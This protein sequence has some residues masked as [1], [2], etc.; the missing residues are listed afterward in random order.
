MNRGGRRKYRFGFI[1]ST[2]IGNQTHYLNLRKFVLKDP[3]V[4]SWWVG[5]NHG[6]TPRAERVLGF[7]PRPLALRAWILHQL[8][9]ALRLLGGS[10]AVMIHQFEAEIICA[11]RSY[12]TRRP[13]IVSS[14]DE[15]PADA[16]EDYPIYPG[17]LHKS[18]RRRAFRLSLDRWRARRSDLLIPFT[19]WATALFHRNADVEEGKVVSIHVGVDLDIW[20]PPE[21]VERSPGQP[22]KILFV[23]TDFERKGGD[24]LLRVFGERF[25]DV[26]EL[27]MVTGQLPDHGQRNV[28]VHTGLTPNDPRLVKLYG[29]CDMLVLPTTADLAPWALIEA[30]A[31]SRPC[32]ATDIGAVSE[33]IDDGVTGFVIPV[34]DAAALEEKIR[35]L[36]DHPGLAR[37]MGRRGRQKVEREYDAAR[38]VPRIMA[39]MKALVDRQRSAEHRVRTS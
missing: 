28:H 17:H 38:N 6:A 7:L 23:G 8:L 21:P 27:H 3:E 39:A 36:L 26:A 25:A 20:T 32:I 31:M 13:L 16:H 34:N 22:G 24:L 33:V 9:P 15:A 4:D 10:D 19:D 29:D 1:L 30:M 37:D 14:T 18:A 5:V 35:W 11:L 12:L 2:T